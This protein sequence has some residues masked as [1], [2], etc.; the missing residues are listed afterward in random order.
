[1]SCRTAFASRHR[2]LAS[3]RRGRARAPA[4]RRSC[5]RACTGRRRES[6]HDVALLDRPA[7]RDCDIHY[8]TPHPST[9]SFNSPLGACETCRGFGRVIGVDYGLVIPDERKS[10]REG[11]IKPFQSKSFIESQ[12]D[13]EKSAAKDG[14]PLD[15]PFRDLTEAQKAVGHRWRRRLEELEKELAGN[16]VRREALLRVA[17]EQGLQDAHPRTALAAT[18]PIPR[19]R[20]ARAAGCGPMPRLESRGA[21]GGSCRY[22]ARRPLPAFSAR[23]CVVVAGAARMPCPASRSMM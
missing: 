17:R 23:A 13:L 11:A 6:R 18:A 2:T 14:T 9:F 19:A 3:G 16:L 22:A 10:L 8:D 7:L 1:M 5:R 4:R 21:T 12:R 15:V 20:C